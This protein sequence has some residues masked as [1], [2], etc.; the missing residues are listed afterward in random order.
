MNFSPNLTPISKMSL[1]DMEKNKRKTGKTEEFEQN[2]EY[3]PFKFNYIPMY[4]NLWIKKGSQV[5]FL[6]QRFIS[7]ILLKDLLII[8][9]V[10]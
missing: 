1:I 6:A 10:I 9:E 7:V 5:F 4:L 3:E 2:K 8:T